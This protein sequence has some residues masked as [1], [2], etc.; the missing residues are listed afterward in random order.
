MD[1]HKEVVNRAK[2][3]PTE[4][5]E[6]L[7]QYHADRLAAAAVTQPAQQQSQSS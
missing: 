3:P 2:I 7:F 4:D 1:I 5:A 6:A